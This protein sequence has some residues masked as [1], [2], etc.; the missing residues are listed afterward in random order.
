[1][2]RRWIVGYVVGYVLFLAGFIATLVVQ[3][4]P[5][6]GTAG[7]AP[8]GALP[9]RLGWVVFI[10]LVPAL[11]AAGRLS[12][13]RDRGSPAHV[14]IPILLAG[15]LY[16]VTFIA[17][18]MPDEVGC[19]MFDIERFGDPNPRCFTA[20]SVRTGALI[21]ATLTWLI[22]GLAV[23]GFRALRQRR[24]VKRKAALER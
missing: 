6:T 14:V 16:V 20:T 18:F 13:I 15:A 19:G 11:L 2:G 12:K 23:V 24:E 1:M 5:V 7:E 21:E 8:T 17:A 3:K 9:P 22:F 10:M 4:P